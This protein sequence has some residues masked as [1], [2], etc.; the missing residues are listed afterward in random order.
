L[1]VVIFLASALMEMT[2]STISILDPLFD[3]EISFTALMMV[4][5]GYN[6]LGMSLR[7]LSI[8]PN[9]L[10]FVLLMLLTDH[11]NGCTRYFSGVMYHLYAIF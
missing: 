6:S 8:S 5:E 11:F 7:I 9:I 2:S 1:V 3:D 10:V 4:M